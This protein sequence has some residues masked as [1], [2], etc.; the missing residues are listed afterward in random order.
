M[1]FANYEEKIFRIRSRCTLKSTFEPTTLRIC[2]RHSNRSISRWLLHSIE[3]FYL[4]T[5]NHTNGNGSIPDNKTAPVYQNS[6]KQCLRIPDF[7][8]TSGSPMNRVTIQFF[9]TLLVLES[10][11]SLSDHQLS[12][13]LSKATTINNNDRDKRRTISRGRTELANLTQ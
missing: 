2:I 4:N 9:P 11:Y 1:L 10:L 3:Y 6:W 5:N 7:S 13:N 12:G 8:L